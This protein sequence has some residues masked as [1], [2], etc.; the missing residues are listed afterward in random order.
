MAFFKP[1]GQR[2]AADAEDAADAA[3]GGA[4]LVSGQHLGAEVSGVTAVILGLV[5]GASAVVAAEALDAALV[6]SMLDEFLALAVAA[7]ED[8]R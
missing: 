8:F 2:Q 6:A 1:V 5:E 4:L 3:H 7:Q